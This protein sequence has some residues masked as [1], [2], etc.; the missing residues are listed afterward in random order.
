MST[1]SKFEK[2][3]KQGH[4][5]E[6]EAYH[7][8]EYDTIKHDDTVYRKEYDFIVTKDGKPIKIEVKSDRQASKTNNLAIEYECNNKPSG[9]SSS[10]ADYWMYFI[11]YPDRHECFKI[12]IDDLR[13]IVKTCK[14]VSGGDG[15]RSKM[16]L[17]RKSLVAK[18]LVEKINRA[19]HS[20]F[21]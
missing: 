16:Y 8:L 14:Q 17:V 15:M 13:I 11:V 21:T 4:L 12:P 6:R 10:T 9:L 3:L 20:K 2:N 7:Y 18:Y 1:Y 5:Y 19:E